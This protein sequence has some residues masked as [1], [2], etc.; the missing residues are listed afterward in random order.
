M[1]GLLNKIG[2]TIN[3]AIKKAIKDDTPIKNIIICYC[4]IVLCVVIAYLAECGYNFFAL[5][6]D[7]TAQLLAISNQ[8]TGP[9]FV[10]FI[11]FIAGCFVD[12]NG[13]G[14]PDELEKGEQII[15]G[16]RPKRME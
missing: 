10:A 9:A 3:S 2:S 12:V 8:L 15:E 5:H 13:D 1:E 11:S 4:S 16:N 14:I 7:V 6:K